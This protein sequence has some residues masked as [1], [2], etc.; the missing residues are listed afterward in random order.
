MTKSS[1][2]SRQ[3]EPPRKILIKGIFL[4]VMWY[5]FLLKTCNHHD[6]DRANVIP[7]AIP[8]Y[9]RILTSATRQEKETK[10]IQ[11]RKEQRKYLYSQMTQY[12]RWKVPGVGAMVQR[13]KMPSG[14][15]CHFPS[16]SCKWPWKAAEAGPSLKGS[17]LTWK[18]QTQEQSD[19]SYTQSKVGGN[20]V[21]LPGPL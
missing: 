2:L 4:N 18:T 20:G 11:I 10:I 14:R 16:S 17:V 12:S 21:A 15:Q 1:I 13:V 6:A 5:F 7:A 8:H 19:R 3:E 9:S